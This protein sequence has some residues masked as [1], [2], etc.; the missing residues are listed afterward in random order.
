MGIPGEIHYHSSPAQSIMKINSM[1]TH[2]TFII[3]AACLTFASGTV[4]AQDE[5]GE[6][7][8]GVIETVDG[9]TITVNHRRK[10]L[11]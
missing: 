5:K 6:T 9:S 3:I 1:K 8:H 10:S 4:T 7:L 11:R 2:L